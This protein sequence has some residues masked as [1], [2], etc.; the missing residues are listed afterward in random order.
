MEIPFRRIEGKG[1]PKNVYAMQWVLGSGDTAQPLFIPYSPDK[2]VQAFG[3]WDGATIEFV[4]TNDPRVITD[5]GNQSVDILKDTDHTDL[6]WA[7]A[8]DGELKTILSNVLACYPR[9]VGGGANTSLT[10]CV[11]AN[12]GY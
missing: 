7:A 12:G 2:S 6:T 1:I 11:V 8:N 4:G 5:T 3:T 10:I 9:V